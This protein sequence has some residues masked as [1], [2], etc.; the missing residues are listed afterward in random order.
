M[1]RSQTDRPGEALPPLE[2]E[3]TVRLRSKR[4]WITKAKVIGPSGH[5]R[6]YDVTTEQGRQLRRNRRH[7]L[8]TSATFCPDLPEASEDEA[9]PTTVQSKPMT[10]PLLGPSDAAPST[11]VDA[12]PIPRRSQRQRKA[13]KRLTY[14]IK[15]CSSAVN[16]T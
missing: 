4:A 5:P 3:V 15:L 10:S 6:S 12:S 2:T 14:N 8:L 9:Q 11:G 7:L 1:K 16:A 13:P